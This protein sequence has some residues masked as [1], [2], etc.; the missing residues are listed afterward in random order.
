MSP[1]ED[2]V[3][4]TTSSIL[5]DADECQHGSSNITIQHTKVRVDSQNQYP[6]STSEY[7]HSG[8]LGWPKNKFLVDLSSTNL[9]VEYAPNPTVI[10]NTNYSLTTKPDGLWT[11]CLAN[12]SAMLLPSNKVREKTT[13]SHGFLKDWINKTDMVFP[14]LI[15]CFI[16]PTTNTESVSTTSLSPIIISLLIEITSALSAA[17][18]GKN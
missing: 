12:K 18:S 4:P 13:W 9:V 16:Q 14:R 5:G 10:Q 8:H 7:H 1:K 3:K 2:G 17:S 15:L 11:P 6:N